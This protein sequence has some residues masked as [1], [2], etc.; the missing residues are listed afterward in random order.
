MIKISKELLISVITLTVVF[1]LALAGK[2]SVD[3]K[4]EVLNLSFE[5]S[6]FGYDTDTVLYNLKN[7]YNISE[8]SAK[9][10]Y[11][12][13]D[14]ICLGLE[15][16]V[17]NRSPLPM[18]IFHPIFC[19]NPTVY[20]STETPEAQSECYVLPNEETLLYTSIIMKKS[21]F[22]VEKLNK[23]KFYL[24]TLGASPLTKISVNSSIT[25]LEYS[26]EY[27]APDKEFPETF[28][29]I[30]N[31]YIPN[32]N[33]KETLN[34]D[35]FNDNSNSLIRFYSSGTEVYGIERFEYHG[36]HYCG[37]AFFDKNGKYTKGMAIHKIFENKSEFEVDIGVLTIDDIKKLDPDCLIFE[38]T[39]DTVKTYHYFKSEICKEITYKNNIVTDIEDISVE[40]MFTCL[41]DKDALYIDLLNY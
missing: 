14:F 7:S 27:D 36:A 30:K 23:L 8:K 25:P 28:E 16:S 3:G 29:Y 1:I 11:D 5:I 4:F 2:L 21:D 18:F 20:V 6:D 24:L 19:N 13:G 17:S 12:T 22:S 32:E 40:D 39:D 34:L 38:T 9:E 35:D 37:V 26:Y 41:N 33:S 10:L 15:Y 31:Y